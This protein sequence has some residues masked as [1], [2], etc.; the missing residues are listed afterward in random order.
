M[1]PAQNRFFNSIGYN[2]F[3]PQLNIGM[4]CV[5]CIFEDHA[6]D[7]WIGTDGN[8]IY[9]IDP[10]RRI[11]Q[12]YGQDRLT[13]KNVLAIF[14]DSKRRIW[15]GSYLHGL[16]LYNPR[17]DAFEKRNLT[18][19]GVAVGH[20]NTITEDD[21]GNLWIGT[22]EKGLCIYNPD[23][24]EQENLQYDLLK[25]GNQLL[26][27]TVHIILFDQDNRVWIGTSINGL[28]CYNRADKTFTDYTAKNGRLSNND[29]NT[30]TRDRNGNIWAGSNFGLNC[31]NPR[32]GETKVYTE[33][34]GLSNSSVYGVEID[35]NN[36]LWISTG[37]GLTKFNTDTR[38][39]TRYYM[40]D[41]LINDEFRRGAHFQSK[42]GELFF[43][44]VSGI[45]YFL[46]FDRKTTYPLLNL[47]FT[48]LFIYDEEIKINKG[49]EPVLRKSLDCSDKIVLNHT[50]KSFT[51]SFIGIEY[52]DPDKIVYQIKM[53]GFDNDWKTLPPKTHLATYTNLPPDKYKFTV[54]ASI[55][56]TGEYKERSIEVIIRP[57][58]WLTWW[59]KTIYL[60]LCLVLIRLVYAIIRTRIRAKQEELKYLNENQVM[61]SKLQFFTDIS[62]EIRSPLT[63]ILTPVEQLLAETPDSKLRKTYTLIIRNGQRILRLINQIMEIRKLDKGQIKLQ[64]EKTDANELIRE[65]MEAFDDLA[66][67]KNIAFTMEA[68]NDLPQ[69]WIDREKLDKV[70]FN[71]LSNA[72]KYTP[73]QGSI[74][75]KTGRTDTDLV[76]SIADSG[77]GIPKEL[78]N[79]IFDRFYQIPNESNKSKIGTGVGLHLSRSLMDI[80]HGKIYVEDSE[81][82]ATFVVTLPLDGGYLK[83]SEKMAEPVK[84]NIAT[85]AQISSYETEEIDAKETK[86]TKRK[87]KLLLVEDDSEIRTYIA[88]V[89]SNEY[90]VLQTGSGRVAL[91]LAIRELPDCIIADLSIEEMDGLE[92]CKKLKNNE[93]T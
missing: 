78:R 67:E 76:I 59:A 25:S 39:F 88:G 91:E 60:L 89:L 3:N 37:K 14:E 36:H 84:Q 19:N 11:K 80:H 30:L 23:T 56:N 31:I 82:G 49:D 69:I 29:V 79:I 1:I 2:P 18:V 64:V 43:G 81:K 66:I 87:R 83:E 65:I 9:R 32:T 21:R 51:I 77:A 17:K 33:A 55:S 4:E 86:A 72:F 41:G 26:N 48:G 58:L 93:T 85:P 40:S 92:L 73:P 7:V 46:P 52:N 35:K 16:F 13:G 74:C 53:E 42:S 5:L 71:I 47:K 6:G 24:G 62:H 61:Q 57:P 10:Q 8:G 75:V 15:A 50:V 44:G 20:I 34:D 68:N 90:N 12:H 22:N 45:S 38:Q 28:S 27:N 70:I 54:R 63:L